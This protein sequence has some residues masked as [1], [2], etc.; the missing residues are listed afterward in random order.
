MKRT[1]DKWLSLVEA[2]ALL[3]ISAE[4]VRQLAHR[5][6]LAHRRLAGRIHI[7]ENA[8]LAMINDR[9]WRRWRSRRS[10]RDAR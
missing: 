3:N 10:G 6:T 7:P 5:G 4:A 8:V 9:Q 2:A 1:S